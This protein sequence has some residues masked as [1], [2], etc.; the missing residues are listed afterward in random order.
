MNYN[1]PPVNRTKYGPDKRNEREAAIW[2]ALSTIGLG[3]Q[4]T[5]AVTSPLGDYKR[6]TLI[7]S[8]EQI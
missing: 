7:I 3:K 4:K 5:E 6:I 1:G 2:A 8:F